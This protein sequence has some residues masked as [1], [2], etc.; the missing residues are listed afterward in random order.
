MEFFDYL[1]VGAGSAG[2]VLAARLSEVAEARVALLE[3]G[4]PPSDPR[5]ADP[6]A[7]AALQGSTIDWQFETTPQRNGAGRV[8]AWPRGR[9]IGGSSCLHAMAHVRGHPSD[10]DAWAAAGCKGWGYRDLLPYF[11]RSEDSPF[12]PSPYHGAGGPVHLLTPDQ[13][14]PVT[15]AYMAGAQELGFEPTAD[16]NG[17]RISG[18]T[19]NTLAIA[20][21]KRQSV[22][23]AYLTP[24]LGRPNLTVI[25]DSLVRR[26]LFDGADR[27]IGI[28]LD[29]NGRSRSIGATQAVILAAGTIG[30]PVLLMHSGLGPADELRALGIAPRVDLPGVGRNLQDHLLSGGNLYLARQP[31]PV[32]RYQHSESLLYVGGSNGAAAP[33]LVLACVVV[34]VVTEAFAAPPCGE[35]Y[36]I[37]FGFTH[38]KSRG[39]I[40]L[41]STDPRD[42]PLIDPNY[43]AEAADRESYLAA[44]DLARAVGGS[45]AL[46]DWR[47]RELLPGPAC[48]SKAE[49]LS[50]LERA[51]HTHHHP[52]GTC[53]MGG[54]AEAV[55]GPDLRLRGVE[56]L[57]VVDASVMPSITTGPVNAAVIAIAERASDLILGRTPLAPAVLT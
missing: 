24:A 40:T 11:K 12:A 22:A 49:R 20:D 53:R 56:G 55:V 8:H 34:P 25:I 16:H 29:S 48:T 42:K 6:A 46:A 1:V 41:T 33:E 50:F 9:V 2:C 31:V 30:S 36:T 7:W 37:M 44:L 19:L 10:F 39:R 38:P 26:L 14:H 27:C 52:V 21:G 57:Y 15:R 54:N 5:I 17:P 45:A 47:A 18:P 4:G 3:A 13:P 23:D 51:A 32:S 35:A 28:E 43:L